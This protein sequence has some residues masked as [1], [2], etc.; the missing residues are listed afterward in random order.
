M[1]ITELNGQDGFWAESALES[2]GEFV[3]FSAS[4]HVFSP[5]E[6]PLAF[7]CERLGITHVEANAMY[8]SHKRSL[9]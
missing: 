5:L 6:E 1:A 4:G 7:G 8:L 2:F 9:T 3:K